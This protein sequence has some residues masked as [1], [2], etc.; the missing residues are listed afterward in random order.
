MLDRSHTPSKVV[1]CRSPSPRGN[2]LGPATEQEEAKGSD[3]PP[4]PQRRS[5]REVRE[6][7]G[8]KERERRR[9]ER[10]KKEEVQREEEKRKA[11]VQEVLHK[12]RIALNRANGHT[13]N[14]PQVDQGVGVTGPGQS[15]EAPHSGR[16]KRTPKWAWRGKGGSEV[17]RVSSV[18]GRG[19]GLDSGAHAAV[20][21]LQRVKALKQA[22]AVL[23]IRVEEEATRLRTA[24]AAGLMLNPTPAGLILNPTPAGLIL[25]PT[26]AGLMLNPTPA[27][28]M[29]NPTPGLTG[30]AVRPECRSGSDSVSKDLPWTGE[31]LEELRDTENTVSSASAATRNSG[32]GVQEPAVTTM[33]ATEPP[34]TALDPQTP[35]E[36]PHTVPGAVE[37]QHP[38]E[39]GRVTPQSKLSDSSD[40]TDSTSKWSELSGF[41]GHRELLSHLSLAMSQQSLR[42]EELRARHHSALCRLREDALWEKTQAEIAWLEHRRRCLR[43]GEEGTLADITKKQEEVVNRMQ[44]EQAEIRHWRN[45]YRSGRQQRKLLLWQQREVT[46]IRR[47][48][49]QLK[50][51]LQ[52]QVSEK[53]GGDRHLES[54]RKCPTMQRGWASVPLSQ[55]FSKNPLSDREEKSRASIRRHDLLLRGDVFQDSQTAGQDRDRPAAQPGAPVDMTAR[56]KLSEEGSLERKA[57]EDSQRLGCGM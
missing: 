17:E 39:E 9:R 32:N 7:M 36:G 46:E 30:V 44:Q 57:L 42:E 23:G 19:P 37:Q 6:F 29:L 55:P 40:N 41:F 2:P 1:S 4:G 49:A 31:P 52:E 21:R 10:Q 27:G 48:A 45:L 15:Q 28:L 43:A 5:A 33:R 14:V 18:T 8:Q 12:Q 34:R 11:R 25:N 16:G 51:E 53:L 56:S 20:S 22:A 50:Q 24:A 35:M 38:L 26:P 13:Q 47:S 3:R 54:G